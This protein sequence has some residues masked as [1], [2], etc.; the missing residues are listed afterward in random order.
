MKPIYIGDIDLTYDTLEH[1]GVKG[2]KWG[3]R[4]KKPDHSKNRWQ[5]KREKEQSLKDAY[6]KART[7]E[8]RAAIRT[9]LSNS[10]VRDAFGKPAGV[11]GGIDY[12]KRNNPYTIDRAQLRKT[13]TVQRE[14]IAKDTRS[15]NDMFEWQVYDYSKKKK[16][17]SSK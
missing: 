9:A 12:R 11:G 5:K 16:K 1:Y 14:S 17:K 6:N 2:M 4:K 13:S 3:K 15:G 10:I 7:Y 8:E